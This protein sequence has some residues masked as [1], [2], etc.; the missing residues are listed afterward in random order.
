M[1]TLP[2]LFA[3][4]RRNMGEAKDKNSVFHPGF[5]LQVGILSI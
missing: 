5:S 2:V 1:L 4:M 3:I